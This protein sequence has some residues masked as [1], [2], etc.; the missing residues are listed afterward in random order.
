MVVPGP[1]SPFSPAGSTGPAEIRDRLIELDDLRQRK[2]ISE[3]EF[4]AKKAELL[5]RI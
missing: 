1:G 2:I 3:D 5:S 4:A